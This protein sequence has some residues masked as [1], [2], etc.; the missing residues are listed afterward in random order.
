MSPVGSWAV[1]VGT[2]EKGPPSTPGGIDA[3]I[4]LQ[5]VCMVMGCSSG[6]SSAIFGWDGQEVSTDAGGGD[7]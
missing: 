1:V 3:E 7:I 4:R 6:S 5:V 2:V